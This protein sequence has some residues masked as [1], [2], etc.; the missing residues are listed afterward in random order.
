[1]GCRCCCVITI[2]ADRAGR[3]LVQPDLTVPMHPNIFAIGDTVHLE[4]ADGK[5]TPGIAP[6]AKQEG[7]YVAEAIKLRLRGEASLSLRRSI[8]RMP[9]RS[10]QSESVPLSLTSRG[11]R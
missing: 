5:L 2:A 1:M 4:M 3:I 11:S 7:R 6:A 10:P 9:E 8:T